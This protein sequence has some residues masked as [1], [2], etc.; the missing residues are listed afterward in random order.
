V[1]SKN[2]H[3]Q[4]LAERERKNNGCYAT[5]MCHA[6]IGGG[7]PSKARIQTIDHTGGL[8]VVG[9]NGKS[10]PGCDVGAFSR[11]KESEGGGK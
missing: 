2:L 1:A 7:L 11:W 9:W 6:D 8:N 5:C 4:E 10:L 3:R